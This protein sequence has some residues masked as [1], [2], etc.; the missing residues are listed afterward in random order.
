MGD[1]YSLLIEIKFAQSLEKILWLFLR[2]LV[3][4]VLPKC[5]Y[6]IFGYIAYSQGLYIPIHRYFPF[7]FIFFS[8]H[9]TYEMEL[10]KM[11]INWW[12]NKECGTFSQLT[13]IQNLLKTI[14]YQ[15]EILFS[16][17]SLSSDWILLV[18]RFS[19]TC[20]LSVKYS[21]VICHD[22]NIFG[23]R[24]CWRLYDTQIENNVPQLFIMC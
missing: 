5:S 16:L 13:L 3:I 22:V 15:S 24:V 4:D 1:N 20:I 23:D 14:F 7:F 9:N 8:T 21:T 10:A 2:K 18:I 19:K 11:R 12:V 17:I 6:S